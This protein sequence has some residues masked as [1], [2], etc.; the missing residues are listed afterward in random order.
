[1]YA[2]V[3]LWIPGGRHAQRDRGDRTQAVN[4]VEAEQQRDAE[5]ALLDGNAL[6]AV[7]LTRLG[8]KQQAAGLASPYLGLDQIV[9][10]CPPSEIKVLAELP[11]LLF[12]GHRGKQRSG[13]LRQGVIGGHMVF[14][15]L[16]TY[17]HNTLTCDRSSA[18]GDNQEERSNAQERCG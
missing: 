16:L 9:L 7:G 12:Q 2:L 15:F 5:A 11:G 10:C 1:L 13:A 18:G 17:P 3:E 8:D 4:D 6:Q 14:P